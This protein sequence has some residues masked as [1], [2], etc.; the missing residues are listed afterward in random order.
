MPGHTIKAVSD[1]LPDKLGTPLEKKES[2]RGEVEIGSSIK[3]VSSNPSTIQHKNSPDI[4]NSTQK[5][6]ESV[7]MAQRSVIDNT[8][9][10]EDP[11]GDILKQDMLKENNEESNYF[12]DKCIS[13]TPTFLDP[14]KI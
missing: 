8:P 5:E 1:P 10:T 11:F 9:A 6:F 2:E 4:L 7:L 3:N 12:Y 13:P 14:N